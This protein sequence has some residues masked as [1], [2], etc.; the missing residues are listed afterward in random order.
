MVVRVPDV[1]ELLEAAAPVEA[2]ELR[3]D[4]EVGIDHAPEIVTD[5]GEPVDGRH[6][7]VHRH[8]EVDLAE[9]TDA[10]RTHIAEIDEQPLDRLV[11]Q[12][13]R[14]LVRVR[15]ANQRVDEG[16]V[17]RA[18]RRLGRKD[19]SVGPPPRSGAVGISDDRHVERDLERVDVQPRVRVGHVDRGRH[20]LVDEER[21]R[22]LQVDLVAGRGALVVHAPPAA[23]DNLGREGRLP[24]QTHARRDVVPVGLQG[25]VVGRHVDLRQIH[26]RAR[27]DEEADVER[28]EA[29]LEERRIARHVEAGLRAQLR[30]HLGQVVVA[31]ATVAF[32]EVAEDVVAQA[33]VERQAAAEAPVVLQEHAVV[34]GQEVTARI[35]LIQ[36]GAAAG[37]A[38]AGEEEGPVAVVQ[39]A[40]GARH[41]LTL[42][43][44]VAILDTGLQGVRTDE[45]RPPARR[46]ED[47]LV[48]EEVPRVADAAG[49][50]LGVDVDGRHQ[51]RQSAD[52]L[53]DR[54]VDAERRVEDVPVLRDAGVLQVEV[55]GRDLLDQ[56]R[57]EGMGVGQARQPRRVVT[58]GRRRRRIGP[59][60]RL[61][62]DLVRAYVRGAERVVGREPVL[63][64]A[65]QR[66]ALELGGHHLLQ[67][68]LAAVGAVAWQHRQAR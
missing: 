12:A 8:G 48:V 61:L 20:V 53:L 2:E 42:E 15:G 18:E 22:A 4:E 7:R 46:V 14:P 24:R 3:R 10:A 13:G 33:D 27:L 57:P 37:G 32:R 11:L 51:R 52:V 68:H 60:E 36:V 29:G 44:D 49:V 23:H 54:V 63:Q 66:G 16:V 58:L 6:A 31:D 50:A 26:R 65:E 34:A 35:A 5:V 62:D 38:V 45:Q 40:V 64:R 19:G 28:R 9:Q 55:A 56:A 1:G 39:V 41:V 17:L 25:A 21:R 67:Q 47:A 30:R 59:P 43:V